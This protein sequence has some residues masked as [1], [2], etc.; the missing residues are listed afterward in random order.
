MAGALR[1][2][3]DQNGHS[4]DPCIYPSE[5]GGPLIEVDA[6]PHHRS[7]RI[8]DRAFYNNAIA[9]LMTAKGHERRNSYL[10][11]HLHVRFTPKAGRAYRGRKR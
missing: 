2:Y 8:P 6:R 9:N 5:T 1:R 4:Y 3:D 10:I 11:Q 7:F